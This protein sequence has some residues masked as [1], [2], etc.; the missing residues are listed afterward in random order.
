M[1]RSK[2]S[3]GLLMFRWR[4]GRLEV[5]LAHPGGPLWARKD[6]G[7][8]TIP[9]GEYTDEEP[10]AAAQREFQ[11]ET[12]FSPAGPFIDLST[13]K[14]RSGKLVSAWAFEGDCD[15]AELR[16]STFQMEWPKGSGRMREWPEVDR[17]AW[18]SLTEAR[19]R[20]LPAQEPLLVR[21]SERLEAAGS[22]PQ[23]PADG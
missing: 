19:L 10:L 21:L 15:P 13:V 9:K 12:G 7:A 6:L 17:A 11:E 3:A 8:W 2:T 4:A 14:Q 22:G 1:A 16:S 23:A 5:L 18:F 20:I